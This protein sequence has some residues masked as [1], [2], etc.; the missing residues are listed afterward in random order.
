[1][2]YR[3]WEG[4]RTEMRRATIKKHWSYSTAPMTSCEW[5][6]II[7]QIRERPEREVGTVLGVV[8]SGHR[9]QE[10]RGG[11][12]LPEQIFQNISYCF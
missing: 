10:R 1:M 11:E 12:L 6:D 4:T 8:K 7:C 2:F 3:R 5:T 9:Q